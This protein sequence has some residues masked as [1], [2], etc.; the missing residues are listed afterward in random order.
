[1]TIKRVL[2]GDL[3]I[4]GNLQ[5]KNEIES[6]DT[7]NIKLPSSKYFNIVQ[8]TTTK[9]QVTGSAVGLGN[10]NVT[11]VGTVDG[12]DISE[13]VPTLTVLHD[14]TLTTAT[15]TY[16]ISSLDIN[17]HKFYR[18]V[19][20]IHNGTASNANISI[21]IN[22]DTTET[23][24]ARIHISADGTN[25]GTGRTNDSFIGVVPS[26]RRSCFLITV[27]KT[28]LND[29]YY[30]VTTARDIGTDINM[31]DLRGHYGGSLTNVTSLGVTASV[32]NAI[33]VNS[34]FIL[35][36]CKS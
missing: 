19:V 1:M 34:R 17:T 25:V 26:G 12:V 18:L 30:F 10:Q 6:Q 24:Y 20:V 27:F 8:G 3:I 22:G 4:N 29:V 35:M 33:G 2:W 36:G 31:R 11:T 21:R 7:L 14:D 28:P 15:T 5:L 16:T 23:N 9:I 13:I 32:T